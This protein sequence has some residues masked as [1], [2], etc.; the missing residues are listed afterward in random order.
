MRVG[1]TA[2]YVPYFDGQVLPRLFFCNFLPRFDDDAW[3]QTKRPSAMP[4][5]LS[6]C[7]GAVVAED[8]C[9][10]P[11][12]IPDLHYPESRHVADYLARNV[13]LVVSRDALRVLIKVSRRQ[14]R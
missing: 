10:L 12:P 14:G 2:L 11:F 7:F 8:N 9:M 5:T 13:K 6:P 3:L 1:V 4:R